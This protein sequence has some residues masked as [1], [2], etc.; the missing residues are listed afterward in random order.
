MMGLCIF[1]SLL[2]GCGLMAL[3]F[4]S[5]RA[6]FDERAAEPPTRKREPKNKHLY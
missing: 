6:G 1:F 4:Y 2:V 3:M 5:S